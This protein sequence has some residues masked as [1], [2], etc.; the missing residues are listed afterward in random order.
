[1]TLVGATAVALSVDLAVLPDA[2]GLTDAA[3]AVA[4]T[5][6]VGGGGFGFGAAMTNAAVMKIVAVRTEKMRQRLLCMMSNP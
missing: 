2:I 5:D 3:L 6:W 1:M 4:V